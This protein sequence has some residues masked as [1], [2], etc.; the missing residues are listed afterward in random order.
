MGAMALKRAHP[1]EDGGSEEAVRKIPRLIESN[2]DHDVCEEQCTLDAGD[3][4]VVV[5][6]G[7]WAWRCHK[8]I[9]ASRCSFFKTCC[10]GG[11]TES[12]TH[13]IGLPDDEP[14]AVQ[15]MLR[16][17]YTLDV[18][19]IY[20][21]G[22]PLFSDVERDLDVFVVADKYGLD[23]LRAYMNANLVLFYETDQ[24]PP[25]DPKGW[26]AKNQEGFGGVLRKLAELDTDTT[27][28]KRA[29]ARFVV[30]RDRTVMKWASV[31]SAMDEQLWLADE[32]AAA[33]LAAKRELEQRVQFLERET[34][35]LQEKLERAH[36]ENEE[37]AGEVEVLHGLLSGAASAYVEYDPQADEE[38]C[39]TCHANTGW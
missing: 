21:P 7:Q 15:A 9:L 1:G 30:R 32:V 29:V 22:D 11:F 25:R 8:D 17:L 3:G 24:R 10:E 31:R 39:W 16:Y 4:D 14:R 6:C 12:T 35:E 5:R 37:I 34:E 27:E 13:E 19:Q 23:E 36:D 33:A 2:G 26:S 28:I 38:D 20:R 18:T